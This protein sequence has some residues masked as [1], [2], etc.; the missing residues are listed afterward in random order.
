MA[1]PQK[2]EQEVADR[3]RKEERLKLA[4]ED[5]AN[6]GSTYS[7]SSAGKTTTEPL[8]QKEKE[9]QTKGRVSEEDYKKYKQATSDGI[10]KINMGTK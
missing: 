8:S 3:I 6:T 9:A 4:G 5:L 10:Y 7:D 1:N 2:Y